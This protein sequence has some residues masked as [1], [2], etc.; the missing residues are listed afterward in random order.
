[1]VAP[2]A[3]FLRTN[4]V[5]LTPCTA[6]LNVAVTFAVRLTPVA[7]EAGVRPERVGAGPVVKLHVTVVSGAPARSRIA[8]APPV[9]VTVY[10]VSAAKLTLGLKIHWFVVPFRLT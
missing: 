1:M 9:R 5:P 3:A 6:S 2:V 4:V 7:P 8:A 10:R